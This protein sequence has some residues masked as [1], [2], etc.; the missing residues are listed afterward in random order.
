MNIIKRISGLIA[1]AALVLLQTCAPEDDADI[2]YIRFDDI[3]VNIGLPEYFNLQSIG[4][5]AYIDGGVKGIILYRKGE[6]LFYAFERNCTFT[7]NEACATVEVD[8]TGLQ[9]VDPCCG[10][11]YTL[12]GIPIGG[13]ASRELRRYNAIFENGTVIISDDVLNGI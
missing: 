6:N 5:Y 8:V 13:P 2:P 1:L 12:E 3:Y 9:I 10:S 7:P 11:V 4:A